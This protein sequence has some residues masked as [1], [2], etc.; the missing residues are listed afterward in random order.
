MS[1]KQTLITIPDNTHLPKK[2]HAQADKWR[3][4]NQRLEE[5]EDALAH[6][7]GPAITQAEEADK[8]ALRSAIE[9]AEDLPAGDEHLR[10]AEAA[11][12]TLKRQAA[13]LAEATNAA[14]VQLAQAMREH[15]NTI[16]KTARQPL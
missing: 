7:R 12:P 14:G 6:A 3:N 8:A 13:A 10:A 11:I 4:L 1:L 5:A 15:R 16:A 9:N 2:L